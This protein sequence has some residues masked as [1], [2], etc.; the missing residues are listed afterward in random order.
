[1][2]RPGPTTRRSAFTL[3]ECIIAIV[4][5]SVAVPAMVLAIRE[6]HSRRA[7]PVMSSRASWLAME[8]LED[9]IADRNSATRGYGYLKASNYPAEASVSE[10]PAFSRSVRFVE[11]GPDLASAGSGYMKVTVSVSWIAP[12]GTQRSL[13]LSTILTDYS[14]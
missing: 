13:A 1:M 4:I 7:A 10:F 12:G 8:L 14:P 2:I 9:I 11:T 5:L 6:T 3:I